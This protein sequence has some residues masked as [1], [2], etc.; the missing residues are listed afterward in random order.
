MY[1]LRACLALSKYILTGSEDVPRLQIHL[2]K[3]QVEGLAAG[4]HSSD[5]VA[6][7][8]SPR[9]GAAATGWEA[10]KKHRTC[11]L[12]CSPLRARLVVGHWCLGSYGGLSSGVCVFKL[13]QHVS[14]MNA[15]QF[16][17]KPIHIEVTLG[18]KSETWEV[19][20]TWWFGEWVL[21]AVEGVHSWNS[22]VVLDYLSRMV[23]VLAL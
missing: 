10:R 6:R 9:H 14:Q 1:L 21:Y 16:I 11:G 15:W 2:D 3:G 4:L 19:S 13:R 22:L 18:I 17:E 8:G 23:M 20:R 7:I 12:S 5:A